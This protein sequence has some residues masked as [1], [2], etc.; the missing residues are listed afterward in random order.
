[1]KRL[2]F[3]VSSL[4][5]LFVVA[6]SDEEE[7]YDPYT[8]WKARN[9]A[10]FASVADSART[11]IAEAKAQYGDSWEQHCDWRMY[12]RLDQA[13]DYSTGRVDDSVCVKIAAPNTE[14]GNYSPKWN[15][16]IR[17]SFRG[18]MMPTVYQLYND[19]NVLV[20]SLRQ[21]VFTE[22]YS[23][24]FNLETAVPVLN[25][26]S[27]FVVGFYTPLQY[28]VEGDDWL[29]YVPARLAYGENKRDMIPAHSTLVWRIHMTAV[30]PCNSG[31]PDWK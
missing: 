10:W 29:V 19:E 2:L 13:Q 26:V 14:P 28:M 15:D 27:P 12:K 24:P 9:T 7:A 18:W 20:D 4:L 16:S 8:N 3:G 23:G 25:A 31:V 21:F 17:I 6:C 5:L 11:A 22:T 30:Y 1:M